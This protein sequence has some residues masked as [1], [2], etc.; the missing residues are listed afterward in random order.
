MAVVKSW[1]PCVSA[2][3]IVYTVKY[4]FLAID[5]GGTKTLTALF[6]EDGNIIIT[7][8]IQTDPNYSKFLIGLKELIELNFSNQP[9][10]H[11]CCAL[12]GRIDREKGIGIFFG[13]L[14]WTNVPIKEDL[15]RFLQDARIFVENDAKLAALS[16][17]KEL[18]VNYKTVLYVTVS[19][20]IGAGVVVGGKLDPALLKIESGQMLLEHNGSLQKW[21]SFASGRA[22][23]KTYGKK[24][25]EIDDPGIWREY[26]KGLALGL[27]EMIA[28]LEPEIVIIGGG[29]GAH[30]EKFQNFLEQYLKDINNPMVPIPPIVKAKRPEE[31]VI[32]GCYEFI[33]QHL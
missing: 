31:A 3:M 32:Y 22:L 21:E 33:K 6:S 13:N 1:T 7:K 12:P 26:S 30:L 11:C 2:I 16:E 20:G 29:V 27:Y 18:S 28:N 15:L 25:S 5:V 17:A 14:P 24:A 10:T 8:R 19:T 9:I 23:A 4:M